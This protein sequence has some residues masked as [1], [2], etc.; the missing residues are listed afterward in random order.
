MPRDTRVNIPE[1]GMNKVNHAYAYGGAPL[2]KETVSNLLGIP[3]DHYIQIN[4]KGIE[5]MID[6]LDG[7]SLTAEKDL[8]YTDRAGGLDIDIKKGTH[9][10]KGKEAIQFLRFRQDSEGDIGRIRRQQHFL[11]RLA[12]KVSSMGTLFELPGLIS[13]LN[14]TFQTDLKTKE[15]IGLA[16]GFKDVYQSGHI[17]TGTIPGAIRLINGASYW[18]PDLNAM[19]NSISNTLIGFNTHTLVVTPPSPNIQTPDVVASVEP[20]RQVTLSEVTRITEQTPLVTE[21]KVILNANLSVEVLNGVGK[22]GLAQLVASKLKKLDI[23]VT[24]FDNAGTFNYPETLIVDWK[25]KV[26]SS[27]ALAQELGIAPSNIIVYDRPN[28]KLDITIVIGQ[29]WQQLFKND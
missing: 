26:E 19:E 15:L 11:K 8:R 23:K 22:G 20:R 10:L 6:A 29:D 7:L 9:V 2:L 14:Q 1:R 18:K 13:K 21:K 3:I 27:L 24:R 12:E 28:K 17:E 4:L 25:G 16:L 5:M